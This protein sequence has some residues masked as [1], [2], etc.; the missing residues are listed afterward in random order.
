MVLLYTVGVA[1]VAWCTTLLAQPVEWNELARNP[2]FGEGRNDG[3]KAYYPSVLFDKHGF[4]AGRD[5]RGPFNYR[6]WYGTSNGQ[7]GLA[8]SNNG[9]RWRDLGVVLPTGYHATVKYFQRAFRG[10][11]SGQ[12]PS[13]ERMHYRVWYWDPNTSLYSVAAMRYAESPD[14]A[15]WHND[16][17][18][19][20]GAVEIV[21]GAL[22][23]WNRGTYGPCDVLYDP[24]ADAPLAMYYNGTTGGD[25][26][27]GL[28]HSSD[29]ITWTGYDG[30]G[31]GAADPVLSGTYAA[32]DWDFDYVGRATVIRSGRRR[33]EMWYSGGDGALNQGI[34]YAVSRDGQNWVR[35]A[36]N[37]IFHV[38][39]GVVWRTERS[40]TPAVLLAHRN[41]D[42]MWFAGRSDEETSIGY[43]EGRRRRPRSRVAV[44][45]DRAQL[46]DVDRGLTVST[47]PNPA[48]PETTV[49]I[50]LSAAARVEVE[51]FDALGRRVRTLLDGPLQPGGH[52]LVWDGL[53]DRG[54]EVGSG[55][56]LYRVFAGGARETGQMTLLR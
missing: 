40:Y 47:H 25:E 26:A 48:N 50:S 22:S 51:L 44:G 41:S 13:A 8:V 20:N 54:R 38:D 10:A 29:G 1:V 4:A 55:V 30:D 49:R 24:H 56:Y 12:R 32:G 31:D 43:A 39:D 11:D 14:G 36:Q 37:P 18:V 34:G 27:I 7:T 28:A 3:P 21:T 5:R 46:P 35:D 19:Q 52:N 53:D 17:P 9:L 45:L 2:I 42:K 23:D 16:Q 6:M 33:Y 15:S